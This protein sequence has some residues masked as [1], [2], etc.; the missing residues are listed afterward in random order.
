MLEFHCMEAGDM[1]TQI[2]LTILCA[3]L[4]FFVLLRFYHRSDLFREPRGALARTFLLG[5]AITIPAILIELGLGAIPLRAPGPMVVALYA[6]FAVAAIPEEALKLLVIGRYC[7]RLRDFGEPMDGIVYGATVG[8][9]FAAVENVLYILS[10]GLLVAVIRGVTSVPLH[11][12]CGAILGYY[13]ARGRL[14]HR[15]GSVLRGFALAV[16]VHGLFDFGPMLYIGLGAEEAAL[17]HE[18]LVFL[19]LLTL[20]LVV[21]LSSWL[22]MR[23]LIRR[24]RAEQLRSEQLRAEQLG[25]GLRKSTDFSAPAGLAEGQSHATRDEGGGV[26]STADDRPGGSSPE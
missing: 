1:W 19:G 10:G 8:L 2:S 11:A 24:L 9:G 17:P 15:R 22:A 14:E 16:V 7:A 23:R 5:L 12:T 18:G 21:L 13:V 20:F 3:V 25:R 26:A 4:P 6:A